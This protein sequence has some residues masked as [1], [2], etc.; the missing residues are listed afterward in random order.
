[1]ANAASACLVLPVPEVGRVP[2]PTP[3]RH[4]DPAG[5][6][7]PERRT[8]QR[9]GA[10]APSA[11]TRSGDEQRELRDQPRPAGRDVGGVGCGV[12]PSLPLPPIGT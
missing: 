9:L 10:V 8:E 7:D 3:A 1:M 4:Q 12:D 5:P 11:T 2:R 6:G